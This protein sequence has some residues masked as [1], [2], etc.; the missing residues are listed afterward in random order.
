MRAVRQKIQKVA[1]SDLPI[2][3]QGENGTGKEVLARYVHASSAWS[4]G[5]FVKVNCAAIPGTLLE[6]ELFGY[7][8]GAFTGAYAAK[9]GR[10]ELANGG[11]LFLDE[12]SEIDLSLQAK[13]LQVLQDGRFSRIGGYEEVRV[14]T[15]VICASNRRIEEEVQ[16]GRFRNDLFY[17]IDG[18]RLTLPPLRERKVD[19]EGL[20]AHFMSIYRVRFQR[21]AEPLRRTVLRVL[22]QRNWPGN[23]RELEN[24]IARCVLLGVDGAMEFFAGEGKT[25]MA[26]PGPGSSP[27]RL[28]SVTEKVRQEREY[29][30]ILKT[31][32]K[33]NWNRR[34]TAAALGISYRTLLYKL[35]EAGLPSLRARKDAALSAPPA[36]GV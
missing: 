23:I 31:L 36:S 15:R 13:L 5:N 16:A 24:W 34:R 25:G 14:V 21:D 10:V 28:R 33:Y 3:I 35:R 22:E 30:V 4:K 29:E 17:R 12:I 32:G 6:S 1:S 2:L 8:Q 27:M 19:L 9:E 18:V 20:V 11:T 26:S 7:E